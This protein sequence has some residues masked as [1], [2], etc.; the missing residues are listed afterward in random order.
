MRPGRG[1]PVK[2]AVNFTGI[3]L[4]DTRELGIANWTLASIITPLVACPLLRVIGQNDFGSAGVFRLLP[5]H[6]KPI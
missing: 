5:L 4:P 2:V 6:G 3:V 1:A